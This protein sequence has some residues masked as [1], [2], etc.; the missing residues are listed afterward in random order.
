MYPARLPLSFL[1]ISGIFRIE[2]SATS[3]N[4]TDRPSAV[5]T[6]VFFTLSSV[7][8]YS[9]EYCT[10]NGIIVLSGCFT[11]AMLSPPIP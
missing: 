11:P 2:T 7:S 6:G 9:G 8:R 5:A 4:G 1:I 3:R 10:L